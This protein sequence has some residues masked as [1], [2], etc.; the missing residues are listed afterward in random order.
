MLELTARGRGIG[1]YQK[2]VLNE[3]PQVVQSVAGPAWDDDSASY[4]GVTWDQPT[5][6]GNLLIL[7]VEVTQDGAG[8]APTITAPAG[9]TQAV[10]STNGYDS[11]CAI[12]YKANAASNSGTVAV[13]FTKGSGSGAH[14]LGRAFLMEVS[15]I[16]PVSP[17]D[18]TATGGPITDFTGTLSGTLS[19]VIGGVPK[20][21]KTAVSGSPTA[22]AA[23]FGV[24]VA[25][26]HRSESAATTSLL[27]WPAGIAYPDFFPIGGWVGEEEAGYAKEG[28][29][30]SGMANSGILA[31]QIYL[32]RD[33]VQGDVILSNS[34]ITMDPSIA[35]ATFKAQSSEATTV[36][37]RL[38]VAND[39][40]SGHTIYAAT[41]SS[42]YSSTWKVLG[43]V[44][45]NGSS[46]AVSFATG[47]GVSLMTCARWDSPYFWNG[48]GE[49]Q[50]LLGTPAG[51]CVA[52]HKSRYF[53]GGSKENPTRLWFSEVGDYLDWPELNYIEVGQEDGEA[54]EDIAVFDNAILIGKQNSL[55]ILTGSGLDSFVL[56]KLLSGGA[57]PGRSLCS[58]PFGA[59]AAARDA[60]YFVTSESVQTISSSVEK[61]YG[62]TGFYI[63]TA[64]ADGVTYITDP[65]TGTTWCLDMKN[66]SWWTETVADQGEETSSL[67][68]IDSTLLATPGGSS[69]S[70][71][72]NWRSAPKGERARDFA[73][74]SE[75]FEVQTPEMW[76]VGPEY[77]FSPRHLYLKLR[78]RGGDPSQTGLTVTAYY[79]GQAR[80][81]VYIEPLYI[82]E[83][84]SFR[85]RIDLGTDKSVSSIRFKINQTV[86]DGE[87]SLFDIEGAVLEYFVEAIR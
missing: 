74:L 38:L 7:A 63:S 65:G 49:I 44:P 48:A 18:V 59:V 42:L 43:V 54:I 11:R 37:R 75:E 14:A 36:E 21:L 41:G 45:N 8:S 10:V 5:T 61:S 16:A 29:S 52:F 20:S 17:L 79:D 23:E 51:R 32:T 33:N 40:G 82:S 28:Y 62:M 9:W 87:E 46:D 68:F 31:R 71:M 13:N 35:I 83:P 2:D 27:W 24:L 76:L 60:I 55:W 34:D 50:D 80:Q 85:R 15:G 3:R 86:P 30:P 12:Y 67:F 56:T 53:I 78:Q 47:L 81:P 22:Q 1:I 25:G 4:A 57:A 26:A 58:T 39:N 66:G 72:L 19:S 77:K 84:T 6:P 73:P 64:Y 70:G 69:Q